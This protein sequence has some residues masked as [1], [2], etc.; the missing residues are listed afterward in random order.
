LPRA[1]RA[2]GRLVRQKVAEALKNGKAFDT[3]IGPITF[4]AKGDIL[5]ATYDINVWHDGK[6][7]K[8]QQ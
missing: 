5:N 6:Y 3:V 7:A 2:P 8:L 1:P 4:D